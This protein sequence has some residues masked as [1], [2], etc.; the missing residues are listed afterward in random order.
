MSL[1]T[2]ASILFLL[3]VP[4]AHGRASAAWADPHNIKPPSFNN[5]MSLHTTLHT[6]LQQRIQQKPTPMDRSHCP[7]IIPAFAAQVSKAL[8][9][10]DARNMFVAV[11][12][13]AP[14]AREVKTYLDGEGVASTL[15][16][17]DGKINRAN[18]F[19]LY[20]DLGNERVEGMF[21]E[22]P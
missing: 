11:P 14:C 16:Y 7:S 21:A 15:P 8:A 9:E 13:P 2:V 1:Y 18:T 17:F 10:T 4:Q 19:I 6:A 20:F 12:F 22:Q 3:L 5:V